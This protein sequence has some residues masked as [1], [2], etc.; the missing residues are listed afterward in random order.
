MTTNEQVEGLKNRGNQAFA[1]NKFEESVN[2]FTEA[3]ALDPTNA[4]LY[5]NRSAAY[6][7]LKNYDAALADSEEAITLRSDWAKGWGRKGAALLGLGELD[8]A[9]K[10]YERAQQLE[11][12]NAQIKKSLETVQRESA[13]LNR[14]QSFNTA[15]TTNTN[16]TGQSGSTTLPSSSFPVDNIFSDPAMWDRLKADPKMAPHMQD[17]TFVTILNELK[18]DPKSL[19]KHIRDPRVMQAFAAMLGVQIKTPEQ[20]QAQERQAQ[21]NLKEQENLETKPTKPS[22]STP[23]HDEKKQTILKEKDLG[24]EAYKK[25]DFEVA[26]KH[27]DQALSLDPNNVILLNNKAAVYFE[28]GNYD[29]C[30]AQCEL[31][32]ERGRAVYADF[33]LIAKALGRIGSAW[34]RKGNLDQAIT[35]YQKS[36]TEHRT[37]DILAKLKDTEKARELAQKAA[38]HSSEIAE[39]ERVAGNELFKE[40]KYAEAV[41][42]YNEAIKRDE[43][44]ARSWANRAACY[45]K[46]G[47]VPEGL[48]DCDRAINLDPTFVKAYIRKA[49]LLHLKKDYAEAL[50]I[51]D[52]ASATDREH[53]HFTEIQQLMAKIYQDINRT[54]SEHGNDGNADKTGNEEE[55]LQRAM[56]NPEIREIMSDPVMMQILR[57]MQSDPR[58]AAE[59]LR[60]P[61]ISTKVRKLVAAGV[62]RTH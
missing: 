56:N 40:G 10:A 14:T 39:Q 12:D 54:Q 52:K 4:V 25:K 53:K 51:L 28:Q 37:P 26:L 49:A 35:F 13:S 42:H 58:A 8:A 34:E 44:D 32:V 61:E 36:L 24:N 22:E 1:N 59:H 2:L 7:S 15:A 21:H 11:P 30:I 57:Q 18:A 47:A 3:I 5:S 9:R 31:A 16:T 6:A 38:Y 20:Y 45:L 41:P 19:T 17:P 43:G 55:I 62:V 60:N 27:Y 29:E 50:S 46:L 23:E 33:K 48:K